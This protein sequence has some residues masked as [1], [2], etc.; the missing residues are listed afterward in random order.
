MAVIYYLSKGIHYIID[1]VCGIWLI[2][3]VIIVYKGI[4]Q[5]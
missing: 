1:Y 5:E 4:T 2:M 3:D